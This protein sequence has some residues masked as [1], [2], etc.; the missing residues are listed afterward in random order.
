[1]AQRCMSFRR[2]FGGFHHGA[3]LLGMNDLVQ[4]YL[5]QGRWTG[6]EATAREC[7]GLCEKHVPESWIRYHTMSRLGASLAGQQKYAEAEPL[8]IG[9]YEGLKTREANI[10]APWRKDLTEAG[11]RVIALFEAWAKPEKAA[12]WRAKLKPTSV[13]DRPKP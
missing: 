11:S 3:T 10:S 2:P 9:G 7:L 12:H 1:L 13:A 4:G 5:A 6:A 8:L